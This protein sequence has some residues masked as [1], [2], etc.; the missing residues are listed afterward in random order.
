MLFEVPKYTEANFFRSSTPDS[1]GGPHSA[2]P[3]SLAGGEDAESRLNN[4]T[5]ALGP[6]DLEFRSLLETAPLLM[7]ITLTTGS[8]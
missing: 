3:D 6:T 8:I 7:H 2:P 4:P 1:T 5:P